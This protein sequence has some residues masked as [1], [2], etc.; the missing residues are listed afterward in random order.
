MRAQFAPSVE[1]GRLPGESGGEPGETFGAF[2]LAGP[3]GTTLLCVVGDGI[4]W[5][6]FGLPLPAWEHVSVSTATRCPTWKEMEW[7]REQFW[8]DDETVIQFSV[9][10]ADH[11]SLHPYCLHMWRPIGVEIP[12]PPAITVAPEV[13]DAP[14]P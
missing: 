14:R 6:E 5:E 3:C 2:R 13:R 11:L 7:V 12:R 10:R 4:G 1:R 8:R 9:P